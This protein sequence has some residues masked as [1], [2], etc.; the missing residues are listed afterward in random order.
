MTVKRKQQNSIQRLALLSILTALVAILSYAG[1]FIKIG[2]LASISLTLIPV[3]V[4]AALC[5]PISGAWLGLVSAV[6]FFVTP[7][8]AF[9]LGLSIP[10]TIITVIVKG[11]LA[12]LAAGLV[13]ALLERKNRYIAV[14]TSAIICPIVNTGIF[15]IGC[16]LFFYGAVVNMATENGMRVGAFMLIGFVGL[17]FV[18]ELAANLILSPTILACDF[19]LLIILFRH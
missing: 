4:G 9:W 3:V 15:L 8:A 11:C 6:V 19:F 2:G 13:Y 5:G 1:G 12:G 16:R 14:L 10:G 17:N 7:D 18:F